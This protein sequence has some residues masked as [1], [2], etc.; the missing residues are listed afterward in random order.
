MKKLTAVTIKSNGRAHTRFLYLEQCEDSRGRHSG[1]IL[2]NQTLNK[3][4]NVLGVRDGQT[5]SY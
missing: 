3:M 1:A 2:P 4:L 5:F